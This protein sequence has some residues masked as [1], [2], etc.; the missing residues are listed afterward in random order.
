MSRFRAVDLADRE[1]DPI[2]ES[3]ATRVPPRA[4]PVG[5]W[6]PPRPASRPVDRDGC[7]VRVEGG[8]LVVIDVPRL[9]DVVG[10]PCGLAHPWRDVDSVLSWFRARGLPP[11]VADPEVVYAELVAAAGLPCRGWWQ[12]V[13]P[14]WCRSVSGLAG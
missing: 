14:R 7:R 13:A 6:P 1:A 5:R 3:P 12:G 2:D 11:E 10:D 4:R 9:V 8:R